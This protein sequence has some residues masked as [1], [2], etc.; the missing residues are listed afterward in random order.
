MRAFFL[1]AP[2]LALNAIEMPNLD[3]VPA[4]QGKFA[5]LHFFSK[6]QAEMDGVFPKL[7]AHLS[8]TGLERRYCMMIGGSEAVVK[9]LNPI[10]KRFALVNIP[11]K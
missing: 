3:V 7:K 5:Y 10:L 6:T 2:K 4:I 9:T 11:E 8:L 1:N